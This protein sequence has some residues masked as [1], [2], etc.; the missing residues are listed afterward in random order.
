MIR[1]GSGV[2]RSLIEKNSYFFLPPVVVLVV[3]E[4]E[5]RGEILIQSCGCVLVRGSVFS[6]EG[7]VHFPAG[8]QL[9][10][11]SGVQEEE[12]DWQ[13]PERLEEEK[14]KSSLFVCSPLH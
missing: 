4:D 5:R 12:K 14:K 2:V 13:T 3:E 6:S 11:C 7:F 1:K 8:L 10:N 9:D